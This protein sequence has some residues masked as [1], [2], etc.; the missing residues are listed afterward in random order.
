LTKVIDTLPA[1]SGLAKVFKERL[2]V[3]DSDYVAGMWRENM[4][5]DLM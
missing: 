4:M 2:R 3:E 5:I 1:L